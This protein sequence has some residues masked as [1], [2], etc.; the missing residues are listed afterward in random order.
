MLA[1]EAFVS[2]T[3]HGVDPGATYQSILAVAADVRELRR[4]V[5]NAVDR[6]DVADGPAS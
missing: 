1:G 5:A 2:S 3:G 4:E 6:S